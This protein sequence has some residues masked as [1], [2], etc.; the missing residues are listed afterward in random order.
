M[1]GYSYIYLIIF[2]DNLPLKR[3][4]IGYNDVNNEDADL[5]RVG[6]LYL[7]MVKD[8]MLAAPACF[9]SFAACLNVEP[10]V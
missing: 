7:A 6:E 8:W 9:K 10:V 4:G 5:N 2:R 3:L 1:N